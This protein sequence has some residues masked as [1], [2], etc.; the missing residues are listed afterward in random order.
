[1]PFLNSIRTVENTANAQEYPFNIPAFSEGINMEFSSNVTFFVGE[2]GSGKSTLLE[3]IAENCGFNVAGGNRNH[4]YQYHKTE[5]NLGSILRFSWLPKVTDGF[6]LRAESFFN[7]ATYIDN[8]ESDE[9]GVYDAYGG[10]SLHGQSHGEAFL[11]LFEN[12]FKKGIYILDEPEAALSPKRQLSFL[13]LM[14]ELEKTGKA[15]FII[16]THS[17]IILSYPEAIIYSFDQERITKVIYEET[18]HYQI[19]KD[20]LMN[21]GLYHKHLFSKT[22]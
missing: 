16:A 21:P 15:Q 11:A 18:E 8:L 2:N 17:P 1:M 5:S 22:E 7:F 12:K 19:T 9:P 13:V 6:F 3:A 20:F 14:H 10:K 4:Y